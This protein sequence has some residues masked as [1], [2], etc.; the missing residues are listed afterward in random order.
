LHHSVVKD[1]GVCEREF[2]SGLCW[3]LGEEG[4]KK[5]EEKSV[6]VVEGAPSLVCYV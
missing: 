3:R 5:K 1:L 2:V 6:D 4:K